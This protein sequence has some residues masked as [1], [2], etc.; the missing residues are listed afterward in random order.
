[1]KGHYF[2]NIMIFTYALFKDWWQ[3]VAVAPGFFMIFVHLLKK[4]FYSGSFSLTALIFESLLIAVLGAYF[5]ISSLLGMVSNHSNVRAVF[6]RDFKRP[7]NTQIKTS[8]FQPSPHSMIT[9]DLRSLTDEMDELEVLTR[10]N[11]KFLQCIS[12][13]C[14][15]CNIYLNPGFL[16]KRADGDVKRSRKSNGGRI[17]VLVNKKWC[18]PGPGI[19]KYHFCSL[20][21]ELLAALCK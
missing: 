3:C 16:M 14:G 11:L 21:I 20:D 10:T 9:K 6:K 1:M 19:V 13:R 15:C 18:N 2:K 8:K 7:N 12:P 17:D 5:I 4:I